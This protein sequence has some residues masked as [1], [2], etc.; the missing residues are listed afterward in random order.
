MMLHKL[1]GIMMSG[2]KGEEC[3]NFIY[4]VSITLIPKLANKDFKKSYGLISLMNIDF[5]I[6][7]Y[8]SK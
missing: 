6:L 1:W 3:P 2:V 4:T 8:I 5:K 7:K